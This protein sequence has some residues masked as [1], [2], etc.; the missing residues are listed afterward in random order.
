[1][2]FLGVE[3]QKAKVG[4]VEAK[5]VHKNGGLKITELIV[6]TPEDLALF[7]DWAQS[8]PQV[9]FDEDAVRIATY[10]ELKDAAAREGNW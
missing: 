6:N 7:L 5:G 9:S 2:M 1:M 8:N 3:L 4:F 10:E